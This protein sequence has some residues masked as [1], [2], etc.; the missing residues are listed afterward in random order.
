MEK[1]KDWLSLRVT[2]SVCKYM[3]NS[4]WYGIK[5]LYYYL[6]RSISALRLQGS[7]WRTEKVS[8]VLDWLPSN[9][10]PSAHRYISESWT[11]YLETTTVKFVFDYERKNLE[12]GT[13][14]MP[15]HMLGV[16]LILRTKSIALKALSKSLRTYGKFSDAIAKQVNR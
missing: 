6:H 14:I 15:Y 8:R 3:S 10:H 5:L 4:T 16:L 13:S 12:M 11:F 1:I 2:S 9:T 7:R